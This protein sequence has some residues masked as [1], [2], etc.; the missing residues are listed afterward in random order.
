M[1]GEADVLKHISIFVCHKN[2][3][4]EHFLQEKA[5]PFEKL[6]KSRT[7]F[8]YDEDAEEFCILAYFTLA[9]Q[10]FKIPEG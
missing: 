4:I 5:I 7:Y 9:L 6:G 8:I 1:S 10:V 3:D 2:E